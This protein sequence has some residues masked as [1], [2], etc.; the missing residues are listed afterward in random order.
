MC[1]C[2]SLIFGPVFSVKV[3]GHGAREEAASNQLFCKY[4]FCSNKKLF[5]FSFYNINREKVNLVVSVSSVVDERW[6]GRG[7]GQEVK[8][9]SAV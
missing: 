6:H 9:F 4:F 7:V 3:K 8:D 5:S 1:R 2:S